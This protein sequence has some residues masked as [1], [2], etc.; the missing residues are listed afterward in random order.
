[1]ECRAKGDALWAVMKA[2]EGNPWKLEQ[3]GG[4]DDG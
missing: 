2:I 4:I 3:L 1:M